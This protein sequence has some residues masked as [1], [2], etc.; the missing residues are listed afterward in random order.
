[1]NCSNHEKN[2]QVCNCTYSGC[3]RFGICCECIAYHKRMNELPACYFTKE[4]EKTWNRSVAYF[5]KEN[6]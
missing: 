4:Q 1:M 3:P 5:I 6:S 2:K